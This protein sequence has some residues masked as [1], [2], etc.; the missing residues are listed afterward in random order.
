M[1]LYVNSLWSPKQNYRKKRNISS[2]GMGCSN[3]RVS[4]VALN[5]LKFDPRQEWLIL[6]QST[7]IE[8]ASATPVSEILTPLLPCSVPGVFHLLY[9][10]PYYLQLKRQRMDEKKSTEDYVYSFD[11]DTDE[12]ASLGSQIGVRDV[13]TTPLTCFSGVRLS[14]L[15]LWKCTSDC[16]VLHRGSPPRI[17]KPLRSNRSS[18]HHSSTPLE[19]P[20]VSLILMSIF[21]QTR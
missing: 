6:N 10:F 19:L 21:L 1:V 14:F 20:L 3:A 5:Q 15:Y 7:A 13:S 9:G 18:R 4:P 8:C 2:T 17:V 11:D 12:K 16:P